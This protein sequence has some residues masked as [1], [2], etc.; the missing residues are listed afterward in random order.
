M[1]EIIVPL[2]LWEDDTEGTLLGWLYEAGSTVTEGEPVVEIMTEKVQYELC[3]PQTGVLSI[4]V[5]E[6]QQ[7]NKGDCIG[8]VRES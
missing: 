8:H 2:D 5:Q 7:I 6:D 4:L 1:T 3:A